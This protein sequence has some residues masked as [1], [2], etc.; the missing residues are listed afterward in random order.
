MGTP[1]AFQI[2][3]VTN[4]LIFELNC[5]NLDVQVYNLDGKNKCHL[6]GLDICTEKGQSDSSWY[7][8]CLCSSSINKSDFV[9]EDGRSCFSEK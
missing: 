5:I 4:F 1:L 2:F 9:S 6:D 3:V 7:F 8:F